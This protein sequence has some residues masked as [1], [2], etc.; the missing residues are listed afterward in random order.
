MNPVK[1]IIITCLFYFVL[2]W[3]TRAE[4]AY[5]ALRDCMDRQLQQDVSRVLTGLKLTEALRKKQLALVL[6][7]ITRPRSPRM[8]AF[9]GDEI[10]YAA[11]LP[12]IAILLA[13]FV[14]IEKGAMALDPE[15][16]E[17]LTKM[18]RKSSNMAATEMY[19]KVGPKRIA[20]VLQSPEY[21][22]YDPSGPGG[23]WC[24]KPY[25]Q[26][27]AWRRDPLARLS[28]AA[29]AIQT[30][31]FYYLLETGRLVGPSLTRKMKAIMSRPAIDHKFVKGLKG[32]PG[33][34]MYRKS[35]TWRRWH[36]DSALV[37]CGR[38]T[39]IIVALAEHRKGGRWLERLAPLLHD[40]IV[41]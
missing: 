30:A 34:R 19:H 22:L 8:A 11:S 35:G 38:Y 21:R 2:C 1:F 18:I 27:G 13:A 32:R 14:Q 40:L 24:G 37:E 20:Q 7:D 29:T 23:L 5:P 25:G 4:E 10:I 28:H 36:A 9:N 6:A 39:Y 17:T 26:A 33:V 31:R 16:H 15:S 41:Q 3:E 12:K